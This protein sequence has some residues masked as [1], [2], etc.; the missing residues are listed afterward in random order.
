MVKTNSFLYCIFT[1]ALLFHPQNLQEEIWKSGYSV[2]S[3]SN[4]SDVI[5]NLIISV[6]VRCYIL[7]ESESVVPDFLYPILS[8]ETAFI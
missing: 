2:G 7:G 8:K 6:V 5:D 3:R 4:D 1:N